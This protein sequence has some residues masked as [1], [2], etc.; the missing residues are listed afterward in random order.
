V[1]HAYG[2]GIYRTRL[3]GEVVFASSSAVTCPY[4]RKPR[5][6]RS[7]APRWHSST[8][9]RLKMLHRAFLVTLHKLNSYSR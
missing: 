6:H 3:R 1:E 7:T 9:T 8:R 4:Q 2:L 5:A